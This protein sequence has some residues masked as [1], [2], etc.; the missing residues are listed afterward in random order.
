MEAG[1]IDR[2]LVVQHMDKGMKHPPLLEMAIT[3]RLVENFR[4][5]VV[6]IDSQLDRLRLEAG[7]I[8]SLAFDP[9][10]RPSGD[11]LGRKSP[12]TAISESG[13]WNVNHVKGLPLSP[14]DFAFLRDA[15]SGHHSC[16][17]VSSPLT[18]A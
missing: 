8:A 14:E 15:V 18:P 7:L 1:V 5:S 11:W 17:E 10:R 16:S 6:R 4:F 3:Q 9:E 13:L 2:A 12:V